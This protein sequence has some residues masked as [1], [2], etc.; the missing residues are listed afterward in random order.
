MPGALV[1]ANHDPAGGAGARSARPD[2]VRVLGIG[3]REAAFAPA[4]SVPHPPGNATAEEPAGERPAGPPGRGAVLPVPEHVVGDVVVHRHVVH[5]G[6]R[7]L[8]L[9]PRGAP[10]PRDGYPSVVR[11]RHPV[12]V[13]VVDPDVVVVPTRRFIAAVHPVRLAGIQRRGERRGEE[14][15]LVLVVRRR[16]APGVVGVSA[17]K[18][19]V[20]GLERPG[21]RAV[22]RRPQLSA[23]GFFAGIGDPVRRLDQGKHPPG[24]RLAHAK[25]DLSHLQLRKAVPFELR[26]GAAA[27][28]AHME[29]ASGSAA[30]P[31]PGLQLELPH[32]G[33][34]D[35]GVV[36]VHDQVR[37]AGVF[38]HEQDVF[39]GLA[40]V[41]GPVD[42]AL[43][44]GGVGVAQRRRVN[45]VRVRRMDDDP[46]DP[47]GRVEAHVLPGL[48]GVGG[49]EHSDADGDVGPD[50]GLAGPGPHDVGVGLGDGQ[51]ADGVD[52]L[53]VEHRAPLDAPVFGLPDSSGG[54]PG[55]VDVGV[56]RDAGDREGA[57]AHRPDVAEF[58]A[59]ELVGRRLGQRGR[60]EPE[61]ERKGEGGVKPH[62]VAHGMVLRAGRVPAATR[63]CPFPGAPRFACGS[64]GIRECPLR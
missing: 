8:D 11:D 41:H 30:H 63:R 9:E 16:S 6:E 24:V 38:V 3:R 58:E 54:R 12:A 60:G 37:G 10:V 61:G 52:I 15:G 14:V 49:L 32:P 36:R 4:D 21:L 33:V 51:R 62:R 40:T 47:R 26:P 7:Q 29:A 39:P 53:V 2:D 59:A 57:V 17:R 18:V 1:V 34:Q 46:A 19:P 64:K 5:L 50:E 43:R 25:R 23:L 22:A 31:G 44:L 20:V 48:P 35:P 42:A 45:D 56:A 55:V 27:V 28:P 13:G